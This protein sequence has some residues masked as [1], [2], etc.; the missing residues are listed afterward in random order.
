[1]DRS[2]FQTGITIGGKRWTKVQDAM[3]ANAT[4]LSQQGS[5]VAKQVGNIRVWVLRFQ[6]SCQNDGRRTHHSLYLGNDPALIRHVHEFLMDLREP[7]ILRN[8]I[9]SAARFLAGLHAAANSV[10]AR[11][12]QAGAAMTGVRHM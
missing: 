5:L 4:E 1:M 3:R 12:K 2:T 9:A 11:R 6:G 8:E 7:E 10:V